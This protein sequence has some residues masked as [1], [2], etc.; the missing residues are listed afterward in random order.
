ML[1][2]I[3]AGF[4]APHTTEYDTDFD[5]YTIPAGSLILANI[6]AMH[7]DKDYWG[8]PEVFRINRW[9]GTNG[10]FLLHD[11]H[12]MPF[13]MGKFLCQL[14]NNAMSYIFVKLLVKFEVLLL[15]E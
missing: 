13:S 2:F 9:I 1:F 8:D 7:H 5:G 3:L 12:F 15:I 6:F 14:S 10:E 11:E 4:A